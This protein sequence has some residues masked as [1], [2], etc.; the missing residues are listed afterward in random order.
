MSSEQQNRLERFLRLFTDVRRGE[1][2][3]ALLLMFDLFILLTAYLVIKTVREPLI[4]VSGGAE[5]KSYAAAGQALLLLLV[6]PLYGWLASKV[7]RIKLIS[8]VTL[9]FISNLIAF[10]IMAQFHVPIGL[11]FF[12]WVGI[13]NLLIVAQFWSFAN[14]LY[15]REQGQRLFALVAF[16]GA[17]G[18]VVG[19]IA[20]AWMFRPLGPYQLM[21]M[22]A[23]LLTISMFLANVVHAREK[24][25]A[26]GQEKSNDDPEKPLREE[27]GFRLVF[28]QRYLLWI[29]L[30]MILANLINTTGE[31]ILGKKVTEEA[32]QAVVAGHQEARA[33]SVAATETAE[34]DTRVQDF[35]GEFYGKFFFWVNLSGAIIQLFFVSRIIKY[36]GVSR[37]LFFLPAIAL[38]SYSL[39]AAA[40]VLGYIRFAKILEN[41][42]DYSLQNTTRHSLFLPTSREAKYK[43]KAAIDTIF[44]RLG[45][46]LSAALVFI[47]SSLLMNIE[48]FALINVALVFVWLLL[49]SLI[50]RRYRMLSQCELD[51]AR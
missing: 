7:N 35:V 46:V 43:A 38:G 9:F 24:R 29:A 26:H 32:R 30:L 36:F 10:Y 39:I 31:F 14:D 22:A 20:A 13:F 51:I 27:S 18:A 15:T 42:T 41:S 4:L 40:P 17:L 12:L 21:L 11:I 34:I 16:G 8:W 25:A 45:D 5:V 33:I 19:P 48:S 47:G 37:S 49:A 28:G 3:T 44:V 2:F 50:G 23:V 1:G 6:I